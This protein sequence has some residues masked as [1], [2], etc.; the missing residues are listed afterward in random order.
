M[1]TS[2][3][4]ELADVDAAAAAVARMRRA[5]ADAGRTGG[6]RDGGVEADAA[7]GVA[8][9]R[10]AARGQTPVWVTVVG[11]SGAA[12]R[13]RLAPLRVQGG[14]V[15][16]RDLERGSDLTIALHRIAAVD[17]IA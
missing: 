15:V 10:D 7:R 1:V 14:H 5:E 13:R 11:P 8:L 12:D 6:A 9:L 17:P 3:A 4:P 2:R 16:A